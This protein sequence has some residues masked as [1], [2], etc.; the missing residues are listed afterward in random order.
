MATKA[1]A[2]AAAIAI[3]RFLR[4][5]PA[6][7]TL[8]EIARA[9]NANTSTCFNIL[10]VL[11]QERFVVR[12]GDTKRY[13]LGPALL[14][15]GLSAVR[16]GEA[17]AVAVPFVQ[18][19]VQE[20]GLGCFMVE[21]AWDE[22]FIVVDSIEST[23]D[24]RVSVAI[25]T[26]FPPNVPAIVRAYLAW[27]PADEIER[28]L[29]RWGVPHYTAQA[30]DDLTTFWHH[31]AEVR[32]QGYAVSRGE[33]RE[34]YRSLAAPVLDHRGEPVLVLT[35]IGFAS[36]LADPLLPHYGKQL[37]RTAAAIT[38]AIGGPPAA[39]ASAGTR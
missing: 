14:E 30:T 9:I 39:R 10:Q 34:R 23:S 12:D 38:E 8:A 25:G 3:L 16:D 35:A 6:P 28:F 20:I 15:L 11:Q 26:R 4:S 18:G 36:D 2:V 37:A 22:H 32:T 1:P 27:R 29:V 13:R 5:A 7:S 24:I 31:L 17:R 19:L 33:Y 21:R